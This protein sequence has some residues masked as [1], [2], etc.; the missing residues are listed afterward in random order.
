MND[1]REEVLKQF[2]RPFSSVYIVADPDHLISDEKILSYLQKE[3]LHVVDIKDTIDFRYI[4]ESK[5]REK[6]QD[7]KEYLVIRTFSRDFTSIPYDFL[8][9]GHQI[10]VSLADVFPKLSYPV[11]KSLNSNELDALNAV[12]TQYQGSSSNQET[13]E[14]LLNKVFK[15]NPEMIETKAD[16]VRFLLSFHYRDQQLPSEI[17]TYLKQKLTKKSSLSSLAVEELLSSQSSFYDYL[18]E[19]WRSYINELVNEQIT[20]KDPLASDSYYH[21]KHPFSDQDV[22]RL[23][24]D[25]FLEG[26]LQPVSNVGNEELP[27]WVKSGV[28]TNESSFYEGKIVYLLDKIEEEI[29]GEPYYK[30]WLDIAKYYGELR[31]FQ[32]SNEIKLDYS[33]K[34]D[35]INLNEKIQEKFEQWLFQNYGSLYN[36]PYHPSPVMVHQIPHYL[37]EKM[38]KKIALIVLDGMNFIQWSQ[39]KS[40]LTEQNFNVEDHGTFAWVPTL[41]S[42]SRQAIFSGKFPMMFADSID[43]TNKEEKLWKILWEDK[44]IKKQKV[45]Y[46]RAL[47]Q[48]AFYREQIEALNKPNIKVAGMVVDTIDEFT[49][50]AIQGYQ[51]MGAEIDIWLKNGFLKELLMELSQKEFSIYI[52]SDH[53]NVECEGIGRISDGVLVQSKGERVRIYND[54]YLRDERAQEHSLLS[55]PNIGLPENMH[56]LLANKQKAF[57][58]KGHQA[59][60]HGSI[61]L[62]EVIVPF[63]KVT[64]KLNKIGEGF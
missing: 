44:G 33:L 55:W 16:F 50:G 13:I 39:V 28:I 52:T 26:I 61:S 42:V 48:G 43:S 27:F 4:F 10:N 57:I 19:E 34:N 63:A 8:Q 32:I 60:S 3:K 17:Q 11:V 40:F 36:V 29:S 46:Q 64:P 6:L 7:S 59:V 22:R 5:F 37:E 25:L 49:H 47:G 24:N 30:S 45:S 53:G 21:T 38:D 14:F 9:I 35:I 41:T 20:I 51:G 54:K 2:E 31:S 58:P 18:Q 1:W 12:Y 62:D 15:I 56:A 23:L